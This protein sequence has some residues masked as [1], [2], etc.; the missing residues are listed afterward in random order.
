[1]IKWLFKPKL[2]NLLTEYLEVHNDLAANTIRLTRRAWLQMVEITGD[3][4]CNR[5]THR[6]AER[7]QA[8]W[9]KYFHRS[10]TARIYR[11]SVSPVFS[12][13]L[14]RKYIPEHPF[15]GLK[16]PRES[17]RHV[18]VYS[19]EELKCLL[20]ACNGNLEWITI[21]MIATTTGMRK[22]A[23]QNLT[24]NDICFED[25]III[26]REKFDTDTTWPWQAKGRNERELPL[27]RQVANLITELMYLKP[28]SQPYFLL[29][30]SRYCRLIELKRL[31]LM[32]DTMKLY[33]FSN[34]D[35]KWRKIKKQAGVKGRF[36]D[37]RATCLTVLAGVLNLNELADFAGHTD[38]KTTMR[39]LG[40]GRD[41]VNKARDK[42][43]KSFGGI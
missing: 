39:Y 1:M 6:E 7:V 41:K 16:T 2:N 37:L 22:S 17:K 42:V 20:Q 34:F 24:K 9:V 8:R 43:N 26:V 18:R 10:T 19:P 11:K 32:T 4:R 28:T 35:R 5:F 14:E 23:I 21:L 40:T 13:A 27:T 3:I 33:P 12:W 36:H 38:P 25:E 31:D 15:K 29:S 30:T